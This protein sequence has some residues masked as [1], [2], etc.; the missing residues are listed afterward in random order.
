MKDNCSKQEYTEQEIYKQAHDDYEEYRR[1]RALKALFEKSSFDLDLKDF[2]YLLMFFY[3]MKT[4]ICLL[5]KRTNGTYL[6]P[7][8]FCILSYDESHGYESMSWES[9]WVS[10]KLFSGWQVCIASDGT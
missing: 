7:H 10:T 6:D 4:L 3:W 8:T 1:T 5:L 2:N 9:V